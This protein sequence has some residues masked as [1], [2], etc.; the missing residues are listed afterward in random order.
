MVIPTFMYRK[1]GNFLGQEKPP[2]KLTKDTG[3][4][5]R[6]KPYANISILL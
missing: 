2:A 1:K 6:D 3:G 4:V 5:I